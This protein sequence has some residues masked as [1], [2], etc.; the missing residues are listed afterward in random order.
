M[1]NPS[2]S[3]SMLNPFPANEEKNNGFVDFVSGVSFLSLIHCTSQHPDFSISS[4]AD[5]SL[6][7][8]MMKRLEMT[9]V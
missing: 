6:H 5:A 2:P 8:G 3:A 4:P 9:E 7:S 1:L